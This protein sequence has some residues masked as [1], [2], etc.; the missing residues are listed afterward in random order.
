MGSVERRVPAWNVLISHEPH[1][2]INPCCS[3]WFPIHPN[4]NGNESIATEL[5]SKRNSSA[6]NQS[7]LICT[8]ILATIIDSYIFKGILYIQ[9]HSEYSSVAK[10]NKSDRLSSYNL[11]ELYRTPRR[12][13]KVMMSSRCHVN[14]RSAGT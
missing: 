6:L 10:S 11:S 9:K 12:H 5:S 1:Y 2:D 14:A 4:T 13:N 3:S 7:C 8:H